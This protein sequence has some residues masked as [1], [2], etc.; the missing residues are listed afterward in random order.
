MPTT[1]K[2]KRK[3]KH[4]LDKFREHKNETYD[5]IVRKLVYIAQNLEKNP[6]LSE[7]TILEI[8]KA[9]ERIKKGDFYTEEEIQ[10]ILGL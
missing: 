10:E 2:L 3:T 4:E 7:K 9:R 8:E 5:E 6:E 1:I